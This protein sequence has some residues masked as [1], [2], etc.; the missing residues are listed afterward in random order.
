MDQH[1]PERQISSPVI[2]W[3]APRQGADV[4]MERLSAALGSELLVVQPRL[5]ERRFE[6]RSGTA[7]LATLS[8]ESTLGTLATAETATEA[9]TFKRVGFLNPRVTIRERDREVDLA[10]FW[11]KVWGSGWLGLAD[12]RRFQWKS[13][14]FW[15]RAWGFTDASD[16]FL[17]TLKP[18][19]EESGLSDLLKTQAVVVVAPHAYGLTELPLLLMLGWYLMILQL[20]DATTAAA[21]A[22][23][24]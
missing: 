15:S 1:V 20:E 6:L 11:P 9:W 13:L 7:L 21:T 16:E 4:A 3:D 10:A 24:G 17:F 23:M 18:G 14:G 12:G 22:A 2:S 5:F 19:A 8:F